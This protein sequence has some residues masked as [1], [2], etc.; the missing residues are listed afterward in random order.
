[1]NTKLLMV[2]LWLG[3]LVSCGQEPN[4]T[5]CPDATCAEY[6]S[7]AEAQ[8][9][10]D[11]DPSCMKTLDGDNDGIA[12]EDLSNPDTGNCPTTSNCGCSNKK[13]AACGGDCCKWIVGTGCRCK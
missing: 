12:C 13:K 9:A 3:F 6:A 2:F 10:F 7:Q 8:A 5:V 4:E 1:M 11:A